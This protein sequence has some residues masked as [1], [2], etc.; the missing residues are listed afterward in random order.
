M[1][2]P[3]VGRVVHYK[4]SAEDALK[5]N[6][7]RTTGASIGERI[8]AGSWPLGA[9]AHIGEP[10]REGETFPLIVTRTG[11]SASGAD[12]VNGQ[13]L[14]DGNDTFWVQVAAEGDGPGHWSWPPRA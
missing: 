9:Q 2:K 12:V 14:L 10:A 6:R 13:V 7:R 3:S 4:L 5:V 11:S 8:G 1:Q